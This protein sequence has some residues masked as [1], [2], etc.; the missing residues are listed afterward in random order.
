MPTVIASSAD[1]SSFDDRVRTRLFDMILCQVCRIEPGRVVPGAEDAG[2]PRAM[3]ETMGFDAFDPRGRQARAEDQ[4]TLRFALDACKGFAK[5]P[6]G[7]LLLQGGTGTGKTH[8]AVAIAKERLALGESVLF[9]FVPDLLDHLRRAFG[10]NSGL[11]YDTLFEQVKSAD[12]LILDDLGGESASPWAEEKLYQLIVHRH[13]SR[14]PTIITTRLNF[15]GDIDVEDRRSGTRSR[16]Q[17]TFNA[18]IG[19]RLKD[20]RVVTVLPITAPDYRE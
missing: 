7:W 16:R 8:L 1:E 15:E 13:N 2:L 10:P 9:H 4:D 19:S 11:S 3:L 17:T 20:Q 14:L 18:A 6:Q 12:L 5:D